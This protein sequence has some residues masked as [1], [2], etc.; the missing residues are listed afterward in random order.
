MALPSHLS[1]EI[2]TP[3]RSVAYE[4]VDEVELPG[5]EGYLG[6]LPGHTPLLVAL[7]VGAVRFRK[8]DEETFL[9]V[10]F[11]FAEIAPDRVRILADVAERAEDIDIRRAEAAVERARERL[12]QAVEVDFER[13]RI[14]L[15]KSMARL[16]VASRARVR[17][18]AGL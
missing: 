2:V 1:L 11:G 12:A 15:L 16:Q 13:A 17:G 8:G 6:V 7:Q 10:A 5:A 9:S 3:D 18:S 4:T 14:A